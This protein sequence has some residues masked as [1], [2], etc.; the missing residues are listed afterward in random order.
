MREDEAQRDHAAHRMAEE[1]ARGNAQRSE[2][3]GQI[4]D[5]LGER[6]ARRVAGVGRIAVTAVIVDDRAPQLGEG[7]QPFA[8]VVAKSG[9]PMH[10]HEADARSRRRPRRRARLH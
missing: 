6:V 2:Q 7:R 4:I 9:Q 5:E 1:I 8:E 10:E 3:T